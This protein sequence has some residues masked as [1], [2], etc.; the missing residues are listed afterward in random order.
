ML[1]AHGQAVFFPQEFMQV[2]DNMDT[3]VKSQWHLNRA[4]KKDP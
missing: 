1:N 2:N 3:N 4:K